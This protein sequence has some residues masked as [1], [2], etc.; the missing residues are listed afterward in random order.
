MSH[1]AARVSTPG[2]AA[3]VVDDKPDDAAAETRSNTS[4]RSD[5][6]QLEDGGEP[7]SDKGR[8]RAK[9]VDDERPDDAAA[10]TRSNTSSRSNHSQHEYERELCTGTGRSGATQE[11]LSGKAV[12]SA[13]DVGTQAVL[14]AIGSAGLAS[15]GTAPVL[16]QRRAQPP[17]SPPIHAIK[18][19]VRGEYVPEQKLN[20]NVKKGYIMYTWNKG[21]E[22]TKIPYFIIPDGMMND[23]M[24]GCCVFWIVP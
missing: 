12:S 23:P 20:S 3:G 4:S 21:L 8:S 24:L 9:G 10:E 15:A 22:Q 5:D 16:W 7:V 11:S 2:D 18:Q 13:G 19:I 6:S 1:A 17:N 14:S